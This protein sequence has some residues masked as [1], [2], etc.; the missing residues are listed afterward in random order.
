MKT[1]EYLYG[2]GVEVPEIPRDIIMRRVE[3]LREHL[4]ILLNHSFH[5]RDEVR[6]KAIF[7][8]IRFW[9]KIT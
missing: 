9:E 6:V 8:A 4:E 7:D 2:E 5:T 1:D 3:L